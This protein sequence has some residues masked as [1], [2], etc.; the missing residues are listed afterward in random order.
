MVRYRADAG[1]VTAFGRL[2]V[3]G[4]ELSGMVSDPQPLRPTQP[5]LTL[6]LAV[7]LGTVEVR[8]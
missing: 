2:D 4:T 3:D 8:R 1:S 6:D 5:T 7:D